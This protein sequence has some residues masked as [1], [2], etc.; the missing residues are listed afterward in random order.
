MAFDDFLNKAKGTARNLKDTA[1]E[2]AKQKGFIYEEEMTELQKVT[3][4]GTE[5]LKMLFHE[6]SKAPALIQ[7][8]GYELGE[9]EFELGVP[10]KLISHFNYEKTVS[11]EKKEELLTQTR[12]DKLMNLLLKSLF[13]AS[14]LQ[15]SLP[16]KNYSMFEVEIE[17]GLIPSV[18][19]KFQKQK[20]QPSQITSLPNG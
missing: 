19:L 10:P 1:K 3:S 6:I 14:A 13:K 15:S 12:E 2:I 9:I 11:D 5:K 17:I 20:L 8:A 16:M 7:D 18:R 4:V